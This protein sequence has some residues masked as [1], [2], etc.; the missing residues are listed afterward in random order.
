MSI[1]KI[2]TCRSIICFKR[3]TNRSN[4][5]R[6][7]KRF[8]HRPRVEEKS[9]VEPLFD[10]SR[11]NYKCPSSGCLTESKYKGNMTRHMKDCSEQTTRKIKSANNRV[12]PYCR[13]EFVQKSNR[14]RHVN[15]QHPD[16]I[17]ECKREVD[18]IDY[19]ICVP[20]FNRNN[21]SEPSVLSLDTDKHDIEV[22]DS[23][24]IIPTNN[25]D[26]MIN[27]ASKDDNILPVTESPFSTDK[28]L[29]ESIHMSDSLAEELTMMAE[30]RER[31]FGKIFRERVIRRLKDDLEDRNNKQGAVTFL[32]DT[33]GGVIT[34][35]SGF[36][37]WL[38]GRL[39]YTSSQLRNVLSSNSHS[40]I[41][42]RKRT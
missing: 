2:F 36:L 1:N 4:R 19:P 39:D 27:R 6:H 38:A 13:M 41:C 7:E 18:I 21:K 8:N 28:E 25:E 15:N 9:K 32:R 10:F 29:N 30:K 33:F 5:D 34:H 14:D 23:S 42:G 24:S 3:F 22:G 31:T 20:E 12:C 35:D 37:R 17:T 40:S 16:R 11:N 26:T